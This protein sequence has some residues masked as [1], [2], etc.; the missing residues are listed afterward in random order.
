MTNKKATDFEEFEAELLK[1]PGICREYEALKPKYDMIRSLIERR[2]KL[3]ISQTQLA[4]IIGT[5]Q[6][7]ISRLEK[8]DYNTT[9]STFFKVADALDLDISLK[10]RKT[11]R[12]SGDKVTA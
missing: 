6:P 5:K 12:R 9:L 11:T 1:K 2:G 4:K 8:G 7:A 3:G 10:T